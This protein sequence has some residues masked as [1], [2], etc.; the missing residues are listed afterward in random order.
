MKENQ[1]TLFLAAVNSFMLPAKHFK[2]VRKV[3]IY[4]VFNLLV[5]SINENDGDHL[6]SL[7]EYRIFPYLL[8][9]PENIYKFIFAKNRNF[10]KAFH[11]LKDRIL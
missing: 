4:S 10:L 2:F 7:K 9:H 5:K 1:G 11:V 8:F 3:N 6:S